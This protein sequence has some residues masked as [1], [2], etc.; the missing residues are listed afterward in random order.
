MTLAA[1]LTIEPL[2]SDATDRFVA[3][4]RLTNLGDEGVLINVSALSSPSLVLEIRDIS[5]TPV[6]QPP[7]PIPPSTPAIERLEPGQ[8]RLAQFAGFLPSWTEPG[9][10]LARCRYA[11]GRDEQV[12]SPWVSFLLRPR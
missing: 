1:S 4:C 11:S 3:T 5:G 2:E 7:P 8:E 10:Y 9:A 6:L 12:V